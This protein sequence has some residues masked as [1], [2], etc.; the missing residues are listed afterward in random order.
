MGNKTPNQ[1]SQLD[2]L[3]TRLNIFVEVLDTIDPESA[4]LDD[5]DRLIEIIDEM[6]DKCNQLKQDNE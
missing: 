1:D 4:E 5:I 3:K 2:Y 6:E